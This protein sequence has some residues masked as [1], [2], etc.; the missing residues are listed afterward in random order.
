MSGTSTS[1]ELQR[2]LHSS[3]EVSGETT[4]FSWTDEFNP[5]VSIVEALARLPPAPRRRQEN[6]RQRP[7][8]VGVETV[9]AFPEPRGVRARV[10]QVGRQLQ[11]RMRVGA[12]TVRRWLA[13]KGREE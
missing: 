4:P 7:T 5:P 3:S 10:A 13:R 6:R 1:S 12:R 11:H 9:H 2:L 8:N